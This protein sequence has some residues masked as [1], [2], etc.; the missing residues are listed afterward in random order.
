MGL[1]QFYLLNHPSLIEE[2]L[3]KHQNSVKDDGYR[4]LQDVLGNGLLLS[5]GDSWKYSSKADA[6]CV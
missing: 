2:V 1:A 4:A 5:H 6:V 3:S